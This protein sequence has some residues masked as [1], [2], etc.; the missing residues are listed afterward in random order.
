MYRSLFGILMCLGCTM[1]AAYAHQ[2]VMDMA[3]RWEKGY[4]FQVRHEYYGSDTLKDGRSKVTNPLGLERFVNKTWLEG[5]YTFDRAKRVT[6]KLPYVSQS[7][8]KNIGGVGVKQKNNGFGDLI[9]GMPLKKYKNHGANTSNLG[10][11]PSLRIP[12]GSS[13]GDFAISDGSWD[14]GLSLSYSAEG[15]PLK[16]HP[17]FKIYQLYDVFYWRN[18][19]GKHGMHEGDEWGLDVNVGIHPYHNDE[20][21]TGL[22]LMW[23]IT[24]RY[25]EE[26]TAGTLTT[27]SGGKRVHTG[28]IVVLYKDNIMFR[29]E[30][31]Y[32]LYE[33]IS[34]ISN[35]RGHEF[36]IGI[37]ITF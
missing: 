15:F 24:A 36:N 19:K 29:T 31:K 14:V 27:A 37:G 5:V 30:Y 12:T 33:N 23:D 11:T 28:P 3:P 1:P 7:R 32:P 6:F 8:V 35:A 16:T 18:A 34:G 10:I 21:N 4:G 26:P 17:K 9:I 13:G 25:H 20:T 22:F 2:P